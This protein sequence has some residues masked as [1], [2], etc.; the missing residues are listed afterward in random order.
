VK[1]FKSFRK[2]SQI[3][4]ACP[5]TLLVGI[6]DREADIYELF[7]EATKKGAPKLLV[8]VAKSRQRRVEEELLWDYMSRQEIAIPQQFHVPRHG[9]RRDRDTCLDIRFAQVT[10]QPPQGCTDPITV[11]AVYVMEKARFVPAGAEPI[12]WLLFLPWK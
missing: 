10:L 11:W 1:W 3:Q 12:E 2:V 7:R 5:D 4:K 9:S 6:G 8:R